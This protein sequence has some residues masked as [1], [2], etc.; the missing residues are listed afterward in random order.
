M[1]GV[2]LLYTVALAHQPWKYAKKKK[3]KKGANLLIYLMH[4]PV[5][6]VVVNASWLKGANLIEL[7]IVRT[8]CISWKDTLLIIMFVLN[9]MILLLSSRFVRLHA[10]VCRFVSPTVNALQIQS[11]SVTHIVSFCTVSPP[12]V[13]SL[14]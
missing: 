11:R 13:G 2:V 7:N 3:I 6:E 1:F 4:R 10:S 8:I 14:K 12:V 9:R 5:Q